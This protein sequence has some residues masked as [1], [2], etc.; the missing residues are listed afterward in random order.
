MTEALT[1]AGLAPK[2][3]NDILSNLSAFW[4]WLEGRGFVDENPWR[5]MSRTVKTPTRGVA[6]AR[7]AWTNAEL[8][9]L[10]QG[11]PPDDPLFA[12]VALAIYTG[13][14]RE[15][16]AQ[17]RVGDVDSDALI[18]REGKSPSAI[19]RVPVHPAIAPLIDQLRVHSWD[20]H[21][22]PG[23]LPGGADAKRGHYLGKRFGA[24]IRNPVALR[25]S[26][27]YCHG[28]FCISGFHI[29]KYPDDWSISQK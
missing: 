2:T 21:L 12:A 17:L 11:V 13:M 20:G 25:A 1:Q 8:L 16:I 14:R 10:L 27:S 29:V 28:F 23:L 22:I 18:V 26:T 6:L 5:G 24:Q 19:R 9:R 7:R 15:E 3:I 4:V